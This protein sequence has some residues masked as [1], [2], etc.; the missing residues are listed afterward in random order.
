MPYQTSN[1]I[2]SYSFLK[3]FSVSNSSIESIDLIGLVNIFLFPCRL[4]NYFN[5]KLFTNTCRIDTAYI[6]TVLKQACISSSLHK[7]YSARLLIFQLFLKL[8]IFKNYKTSIIKILSII[9]T[10]ILIGCIVLF[11]RVRRNANT[12]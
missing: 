1:P 6:L 7:M 12:N 10:K 5:K 8:K 4:F 3:N 9:K 2:Y 11:F